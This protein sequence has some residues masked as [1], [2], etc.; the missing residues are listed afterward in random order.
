MRGIENFEKSWLAAERSDG[1]S[2][3][4]CG[5]AEV[6]ADGC[7]NVQSLKKAAVS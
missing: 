1:E 4:S 7:V 6:S 2:Y 3:L 5:V